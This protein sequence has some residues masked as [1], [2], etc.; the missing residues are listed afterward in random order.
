MRPEFDAIRAFVLNGTPIDPWPVQPVAA[1]VRVGGLGPLDHFVAVQ[2]NELG[3]TALVVY[4][5][6]LGFL[7][8]LGD[9][10]YRPPLSTS[11]R[12]NQVRT[13]APERDRRDDPADLAIGLPSFGW[14]VAQTDDEFRGVVQYAMGPPVDVRSRSSASC[15]RAGTMRACREG[16]EGD[17]G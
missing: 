5:G 1:D 8:R 17:C 14:A 4:F 6:L 16:R 3:T 12:V 11:Y 7:V 10:P 13:H 2:A 15:M 9:D